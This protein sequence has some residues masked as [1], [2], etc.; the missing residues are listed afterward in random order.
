MNVLSKIAVVGLLGIVAGSLGA[1][2]YIELNRMSMERA[3]LTQ[4]EAEG[5]DGCNGTAEL[6]RTPET[7]GTAVEYDCGNGKRIPAYGW[8][9]A[10]QPARS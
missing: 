4:S 2:S 8:R 7:F 5:P 9:P 1:L 3:P 6:I 10:Q